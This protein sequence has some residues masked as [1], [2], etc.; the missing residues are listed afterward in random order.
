MNKQS[1]K[2]DHIRTP[3][4]TNPPPHAH[5]RSR[6]SGDSFGHSFGRDNPSPDKKFATKNLLSL[7]DFASEKSISLTKDAIRRLLKNKMAVLALVTIIFYFTITLLGPVLPI[8]SYRFQV[9]EHRNLPPTW[10][11]TA[12][13]LWYEREKNLTEAYAQRQNRELSPQEHAELKEIL[14]R[15]EHDR[16]SIE[17]E[18]VNPHTRHYLLGTDQLGRDILARTIF[19]GRISI[20]I[21]LIGALTAVIIG[22]LVGSIAGFY[23]GKI[24]YILMRFVDI[25]YGLPYMLLVII[26]MTLLGR[27]VINLY[28]ALA[29]ISW[30]TVSRVVRG[31]IISLKNAE[32]VEAARTMGANTVRIIAIHMIPNTLGVIIVFTTLRIP[33]FI[34]TEAFLSFLGLGV[35]APLASWGSLIGESVPLLE[36]APWQ[37]FV[38]SIAMTFFL[39]AMNF[40]G[41]GLRDAFD[42]KTK[43]R[44]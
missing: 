1:T 5:S 35:S 34:I 37:L 32:F 2:D 38:P 36:T 44:R 12:G 24:D 14:Y 39:F 11:K 3:S 27:N 8:Y 25:M 43:V 20:A 21:G 28:F 22:I 30:L 19:G 13:Q 10:N 16:I 9:L 29:F 33:V 15:I 26:L 6:F 4:S 42:P 7:Q 41:D 18:T 40:L 31:Q 23:G 17:D